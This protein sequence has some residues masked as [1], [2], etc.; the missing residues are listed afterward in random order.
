M[1]LWIGTPS[2]SLLLMLLPLRPNRLLCL[3]P[4]RTCFPCIFSYAILCRCSQPSQSTSTTRV[5]SSNL[6]AN[7]R[8]KHIHL[9]YHMTRYYATKKFSE[10]EYASTDLE[11]CRY[12]DQGPGECQ[13][14]AVHQYAASRCR[15]TDIHISILVS[16]R[17]RSPNH[18]RRLE[19]RNLHLNF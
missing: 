12:H 4:P 6:I 5:Q 3:P 18:F 1:I 15:V 11:H 19:S 16:P 2:S 13:A 7:K 8:S 10:L 14:W 17:V 9:R